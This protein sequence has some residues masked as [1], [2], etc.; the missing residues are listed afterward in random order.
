MQLFLKWR[1]TEAGP[2]QRSAKAVS[3][4]VTFRPPYNNN[5]G[6]WMMFSLR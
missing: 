2:R 4:S 6:P 1:A 5:L 3:I